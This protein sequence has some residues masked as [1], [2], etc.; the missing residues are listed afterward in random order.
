MNQGDGSFVN[1]ALVAGVALGA[2]GERKANMGVD[3]GD[4]D[5]D[6]DDD[7]FITELINQGSTLYVNN[8]KGIFEEQSAARG[9][10]RPSLPFTG[11]GAAWIDVDNDGWLDVLSVNG[12]VNRPIGNTEPFPLGQPK[13]LLRNRG[14][15]FEDATARGGAPLAAVEASRG[16]AFGDIDNDGDVDVVVGNG[17]GAARL[18]LNTIGASRHW[19]GV[20]L[21][22]PLGPGG[23]G[24]TRDVVGARVAFVLPDGTTLWRRARA[25]GSYASANDPRVVAGLGA[26]TTPP[27]VEVYWPDGGKET[28][29]NLVLDTYTVLIR[30]TGR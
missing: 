29:S 1:T 5:A 25:D 30:G 17:A 7:L 3:A 14:G 23:T 6:G 22:A 19:V 15:Q 10:R 26:S 20:R 21:V 11:F 8:G 4:F 28:W 24:G 18:L 13:L 2:N 9:V 27:G 16:A 12:Q